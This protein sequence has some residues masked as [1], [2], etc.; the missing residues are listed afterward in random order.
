VRTRLIKDTLGAALLCSM[1][2]IGGCGPDS[3][4][5]TVATGGGHPR[6]PAK[7]SPGSGLFAVV[8]AKNLAY[9]PL[10]TLDNMES[11]QVAVINLGVDPDTTDPR[12]TTISLGHSDIPT[13]TAY[14][15]DD[16]LILVVGGGF[17]DVIDQAT[18]MPVMGS[19]FA[20][21]MGSDVG[22]TGQVLY[23]TNTNLAIIGLYSPT[24]GFVTFNPVTHA[25]GNVIPASYPEAFSL[26]STTNV[27]M[28]ASDA[29]GFGSMDAVDVTG[30]RACTL[31]DS[32][33]G[34]D[35][36]GAS[37]DSATN[38]TVISNEDGTASVL[39]LNG[40][41][42]NPG[43]GTPCTLDENNPPNSVLVNGLPGGTAGSAVN[44]KTHQAFLIEDDS[45]GVTLLQLPK[46]PV[47]GNLT[48]GK[49]GTPKISTIPDTP[50]GVSWATQGDPYAVAVGECN[51]T[52]YAVDSD[53]RF[54]VQIDLSTLNKNP[55]M[56]STPLPAGSCAG[57]T[58]TLSCK[59]GHG[60]KF[61]PLPG[62]M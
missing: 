25:F 34:S 59:N 39:N 57:T 4:S 10:N 11:G 12:I 23:N 7:T 26:N 5:G 2:V 62:V 9:V 36:D 61:F 50:E 32:N 49:L 52:G 29:T 35:L 24:S 46:S 1:L 47:S 14:D 56:I 17:V 21:P 41:V 19:P 48:P 33:I 44:G 6:P 55:G 60:V 54:L 40:S 13:G 22:S 38:I 45:N 8:C 3:G 27:V 18:N 37:T 20:L 58:T 53:F 30:E 51:N 15:D 16:N 43:A 28:D 31:T 42:F